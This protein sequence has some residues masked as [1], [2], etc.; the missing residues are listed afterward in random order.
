LAL[1]FP[2]NAG[3]TVQQNIRYLYSTDPFDSS[4]YGNWGGSVNSSKTGY[5]GISGAIK[6]SG[7]SPIV[8]SPIAATTYQG[9]TVLAFR[10]Y[11]SG[12]G[13]NVDNGDILLLTQVATAATA[14][15]ASTTISWVQTN[16]NQSN[17]NGVGLATDQA[18]LYLTSTTYPTFN[19]GN[20]SPEIWSLAPSSAGS[21]QWTLGTEE[22]VSGP[23]FAAS[24]YNIDNPFMDTL[25][26]SSVLNPFLL[27]GKLM[28][29]WSGGYGSNIGNTFDVQLAELNTTIGTPSQQTLAGYSLDGNIDINGDGFRDVL[30]SDIQFPGRFLSTRNSTGDDYLRNRPI[31]EDVLAPQPQ[32]L[33][34][35]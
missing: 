21:G 14:S 29:A 28:A 2:S 7:T 25:H 24:F 12:S 10:S 26:L 5:S 34:A 17:S 1:Y 32:S 22:S 20:P 18:L 3:S 15:D 13:S 23:G 33:R 9:R 6:V 31:K 19:V 8:T 27:N 30:L 16:T 35:S 11:V 4:N